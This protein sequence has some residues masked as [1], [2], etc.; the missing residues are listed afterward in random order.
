MFSESRI[1][2]AL[3]LFALFLTFEPATAS[4]GAESKPK[5]A[6]VAF[7]LYGDQSVFESEA[8]GAARIV[9]DR[10]GGGPVIVRANTKGREDTTVETVRATLQSAAKEIDVQNDILFLILTSHGSRLGLSVKAGTRQE[11]LSPSQLVLMLGDTL[12]RHRAVVISACY[13]GVFV[14]PLADPDTL[15]ITA[16]DADD[17]S[18][19]CQNG[20]AW[21][22]FG[23]AF[24][25]TALRRAPNLRDAFATAS[26]LVRKRELQGRQ[27]PSNPQMAGGENIEHLLKGELDRIVS[28][29][30]IGLDPKYAFARGFAY[31]AKG[32]NDR[33][34]AEY[35][36]AVRFDPKDA[37]AYHNRG[38]LYRV[39]GDNDQAI[40]D[41][42]E[43]IRLDPKYLEARN[44]RGLAYS[45]KGDY[46]RAIAD[47]SEAIRLDPKYV[48]GYNNRGFAYGAKR[49]YNRAIAEY[50]EAIRTAP[51]YALAY[52]NRGRAYRAKGDNN[53]AIADFKEAI[54]LDPT[55]APATVPGVGPP[56]KPSPDILELTR[57]VPA[58]QKRRLDFL[59]SINPNCSSMGFAI[60]RVLE[61]PNHGKLAVDNGTAYP[62]FPQNNQRYEC[63][64]RQADGVAVFYEP[65]PEFIGADSATI[66]VIF[67]S[68]LSRK[69]HYA[70]EVK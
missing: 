18:F 11:T 15:I 36:E 50:A 1:V 27:T 38:R 62:N 14:R 47:Y 2:R 59:Y 68:G 10:F 35:G 67:P 13:S 20:T 24:F 70:I 22:Y 60:V 23:D 44:S 65:N 17:T 3:G 8:K 61:E 16:A 53:R 25:N 19:G 32:D 37:V 33:A 21:T 31:D 51:N 45:A 41:Y 52:Y 40:A 5:V 39:K 34:I 30:A 4:H 28:R 6:V 64:R 69:Q 48:V 49:D 66:D 43:A 54:R 55:I 46:D 7:G 26:S 29:E 42:T 56:S 57:T 9:A 12:V 58:G 63:N